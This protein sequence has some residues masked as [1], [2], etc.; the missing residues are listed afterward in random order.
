MRAWWVLGLR[1]ALRVV[2]WCERAPASRLALA[3]AVALPLAVSLR[4]C[5]SEGLRLATFNIRRFGVE[6]TDMAQLVAM[7]ERFDA[8]IIAVQEIQKFERL[9]E[10]AATLRQRG[11]PYVAVATECGGRRQMHVGF[12]YDER[13]A[14][15]K[16]LREFRELLPEEGGCE[17]DRPGLLGV[18]ESGGSEVHALVVHLKAGDGDNEFKQ[19][20]QQWRRLQE[21]T[22][23]LKHEG[24]RRIVLLGDMNSTGFLTNRRGERD[25]IES[26]A[27]DGG[28][29]VAT[30]PLSCTE[31]YRG[32]RDRMLPSLLD[33]VLVSSSALVAGSVEVHAHCAQLRCAPQKAG[34]MPSSYTDVSDH[35]PVTLRLTP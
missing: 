29:T 22:S 14:R 15:L 18:F 34:D 3:A 9:Q 16:Q 28:M 7:V 30:A 24:A 26:F 21:L 31:Y 12:L 2:S 19:R 32:D 13:R 25:L 35:C 27:R 33:H 17:G 11:R 23:K 6:P 1:A 5:P 20:S 4:A 8:D 10:L